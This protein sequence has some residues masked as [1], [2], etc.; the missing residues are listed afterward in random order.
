M[1]IY[2]SLNDQFEQSKQAWEALKRQHDPI[3]YSYTRPDYGPKPLGNITEI[4][5]YN[6]TM[7]NITNEQFQRRQYL[8]YARPRVFKNNRTE[9]WTEAT[10]EEVGTHEHGAPL[11]LM[12]ELYQECLEKVL[13]QDP[14]KNTIWFDIHENGVLRTCQYS[15]VTCPDY[16]RKG[17]LVETLV[18]NN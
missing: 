18:I 17:V 11:K 7:I 6:W 4:R 13:S 10:P 15:E 9:V 8:R 3:S 2:T 1:T 16:C 5:Q 14:Q 12:E